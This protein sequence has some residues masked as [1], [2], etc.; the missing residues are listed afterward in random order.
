MYWMLAAN[1]YLHALTQKA[2]S[3]LPITPFKIKLYIQIYIY[4]YIRVE[5]LKSI[6]SKTNWLCDVFKSKI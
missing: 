3:I 6:K 4:I 5:I 2:G 1:Q